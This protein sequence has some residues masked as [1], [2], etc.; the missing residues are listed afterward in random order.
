[1]ANALLDE[2][3]QSLKSMYYAE[4]ELRPASTSPAP[5]R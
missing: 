5:L 4:N 1:M 2:V 3:P